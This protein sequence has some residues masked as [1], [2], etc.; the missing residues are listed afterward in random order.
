VADFGLSKIGPA[1]DETPVITAVRG[2]IGY[3]DAEYF[4][5]QQLTEKSDVYS[6]DVV[7]MEVT[8]MWQSASDY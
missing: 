1:I 6:F 3:L 2:S 4:R 5:R 7:L 8:E